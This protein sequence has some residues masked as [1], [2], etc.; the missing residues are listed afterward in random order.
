MLFLPAERIGDTVTPKGEAVNITTASVR[1]MQYG[2]D[3]E[4]GP[5]GHSL[6]MEMRNAPHPR[7]TGNG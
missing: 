3:F 7:P 4:E 5:K 2:Q 6:F 1:Y